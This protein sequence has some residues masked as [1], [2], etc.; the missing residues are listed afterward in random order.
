MQKTA[1]LRRTAV[2]LGLL[3]LW[4][5]APQ[6]PAADWP[7]FRGD[8][9]RSGLSSE[10][11]E[12]P[13]KTAWVHRA[14]HEPCPAW[15][16]LPAKRDISHKI[17]P[18]SPTSTFDC[19][20]QPVIAGDCLYYGSSADD[21]LYCIEAA[22]GK[23]RWSFVT[24][25]PVRLAPTVVGGRVYAGSDDGFV[26]CLDADDGRL[27]WKYGAG[28]QDRRLPGNGRMISLW[29][30][31]CG[32]VVD[33]GTVYFCAG[34]FPS[35]GAY[36]CAVGAR[37]G[38]QIWKEK[39]D[40]SPQ[41]H[42]LASQRRLFV[43]TGRDAP[44]V[45]DR[46]TGRRLSGPRSGAGC[47]AVVIDDVLMHAG[48]E[49]GGVHL[50]TGGSG[51]KVLFA[52]GDRLIVN[53]PIAYIVGG[54]RLVALDRAHYV[55]LGR[56]QK[57]KEKTPEDRKRIEQLG[58]NRR[59]YLKWN[60]PCRAHCELVMAAETIFAGGDGEVVAYAAADGRRLWTGAVSGKAFGLAVSGGSLF[61]STDQGT[62]HCFRGGAVPDDPAVVARAPGKT[63]PYAED[64]LTPR[65]RRAA[66]TVI[67]KAGVRKGY[68]LVLGSGTGR[69]AYEIARRSDFRVIGVEAD[70]KKVAT[71]RS[72]L[73]EAGLY[74]SRI[75]VH[76]GTLE[77]LPYPTHFAN[78]ITSD[79]AVVTGRP[80]SSATEVYRVLRPCGGTV[81]LV[82]PGGVAGADVLKKWASEA[83]P[84]WK[85]EKDGGDA[86]LGTAGRGRLPGA[87]QWTH[88][89]ADSGNSACSNDA[90]PYG[91]VDLRWFGR[92]G[93]RNMVDRHEKTVA[94]LYTNGRLFVSGDNYIAAA[95][96]YNGTILWERDLPNSIRLGAFKNC[97]NM[98][99]TDECLYVASAD[100]CT[101]LDVQTGEQ[102][103]A[104]PL[105]DY[106][107][108]S[109]Q[110][111]G[112]LAS[113]G[114]VLLG[115]QTRPG[116]TFRVQDMPTQDLI[117]P[118]YQPVVCSDS[119]FALNRHTG[120]KLW[121]YVPKQGVIVNPTI[122]AGGGRVYCVES[123]HPDAR[124][125]ADGRVKLDV[126]LGKGSDLLA[127]DIHTGE[128]LWKKPAGLQALQHVIFLSYAKE[129]LLVTGT[130]NVAIGGQQRV[131]YDL[132][133]FDASSGDSLW[134]NTQ[135]P[136]PDH[137][138][139]GPHGEQ[140][141]H[142][143]I[144]G[145]VVYNTGFACKLRTGEPAG[146]W[147]WQKSE[148][149][150][151]ISCSASCGFS[152]YSNPR[153]FQ[154]KTG[155]YTALTNV[156][157]PGCWINIIPAGGLILI[158][159]QSSGCT[160]EYSIQTSIVLAPRDARPQQRTAGGNDP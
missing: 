117:W 128:V 95:D 160:C 76:H 41:G 83:I 146:G 77:S 3:A 100:R 2:V 142:S 30:V 153:M 147:K 26:Y 73:G 159:E 1:R 135:V 119:L 96:A 4:S 90:L 127:L 145:D 134:N 58:G 89:Y 60:V 66:E 42:L 116:A 82:C 52:S 88:F 32:V 23:T 13:L 59:T 93:P 87:G 74:G 141:Q 84:G 129:T 62:I 124:K 156:T 24:E 21:G 11:L 65:Y 158:P 22:T 6:A 71:A 80:P 61:V 40:V 123:T 50:S 79:E 43:P 125:V 19:A 67:R 86:W 63:P 143:A 122:A 51:E 92:P 107:D 29:P 15:P 150:G 152:R 44:A 149:C 27:I 78:L 115:S 94:P 101:A 133:A 138:L 98:V 37:D 7:T 20:F 64:R 108:G 112:Y 49:R 111:W 126:L 139:R 5:V 151:T 75:A 56:L 17:Q 97:S 140:V 36:L 85:V 120:K 104:F 35:R 47:F 131:R 102:K 69:L 118:D 18:L 121:T 68:C 103:L 39:I 14:V 48:G 28:P 130:K 91:P 106:A 148:K 105:E 54:G 16:E 8:G 53:G 10:R 154:L 157:R 144:V 12:L 9:H 45:Y 137:I 113:V 99:V 114:D 70:Q 31:R 38:S 132:H 57:K 46:R 72:L 25:G 110:E 155:Q 34:V 33:G 136:I 55:E 109:Q 81:A